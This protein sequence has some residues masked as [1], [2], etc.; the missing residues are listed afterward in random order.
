MQRITRSLVV[1]LLIGA[2][3]MACAA[4]RPEAPAHAATAAAEMPSVTSVAAMPTVAVR[5]PTE[6]H[7]RSPVAPL[8]SLLML[9]GF[10]GM[11]ALAA[12]RDTPRRD[13]HDLSYPVDAAKKIF[14][15]AL[16]VM[17]AGFLNPGATALN[18]IAVGRAKSTVDNSAGLA[19]DLQAPVE[20]GVFRFANSAAG[21]LIA[22]TEVGKLCYIVDDQTVAKT[23]GGGTRSA[24][25]TVRDVDVAGVW[26][27]I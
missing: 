15:G 18:L 7:R 10:A 16:V 4:P 14:Q 17:K 20:R 3:A 22:L 13:G 6:T 8:G 5:N 27:E 2:A 25:G 11:T 1:G 19:G 12:D 23:D 24:A 21:D 9:A 26:V